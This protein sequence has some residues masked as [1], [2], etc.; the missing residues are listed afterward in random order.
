LN[1]IRD[2]DTLSRI[3]GDEFV[4][5]FKEINQID[6]VSIIAEKITSTFN[7]PILVMNH[8]INIRLSI[9][10]AVSSPFSK[11]TIRSLLKKADIALY[12]AKGAGRNGY[13]I[14]TDNK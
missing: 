10:I 2:E 13:R 7:T 11:E 12:E 6:D 4:I 5:V 1:F 14:F 8:S 3:G 9:G